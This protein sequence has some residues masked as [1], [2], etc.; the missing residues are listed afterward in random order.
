MIE[1]SREQDRDTT[2]ENVHFQ[3]IDGDFDGIYLRVV[4]RKNTLSNE[5]VIL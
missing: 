1:L 5:V 4:K 3:T 2:T